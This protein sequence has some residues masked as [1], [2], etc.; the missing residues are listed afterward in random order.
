MILGIDTAS[1][2]CSAALVEAG[3]V[4]AYS[5]LAGQSA[6]SSHLLRLIDDLCAQAGVAAIDT[7]GVAVNLGPGAFTGLRV[8][9][10]TAQG[11]VAAYQ[12]PLVG[13]STFEA[14]VDAAA[15]WDGLICPVIE[16]RRG[17][18]YA[19]FYRRQGRH[20]YETMPGRAV[21]PDA[22]CSLV[23]ERTLFLGSGVQSYGELLAS[24]LDGLAVCRDLGSDFALAVNVARLGCERLA[25]ATLGDGYR[26][27][28]IYIRPADARLPRH[29]TSPTVHGQEKGAAHA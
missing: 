29:K 1:P 23:Q 15:D 10:A 14:L 12:R 21:T 13:C 9:L 25:V 4:I 5:H 6:A 27:T 24:R 26:L 22:L 7:A 17:E 3:Q 20:V 28:P 16:A 11:L 2:S 8:G 19:A 18:V